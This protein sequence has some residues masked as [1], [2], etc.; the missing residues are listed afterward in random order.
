MERLIE[1]HVLIHN[2]EPEKAIRLTSWNTT[3]IIDL[4]FTTHEM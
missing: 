4:T 3:A 2:N 1:R